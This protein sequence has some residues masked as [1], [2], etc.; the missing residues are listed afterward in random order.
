MIQ[1]VIALII[2]FSVLSFVLVSFCRSLKPLKSGKSGKCNGCSGCDMLNSLKK[3]DKGKLV[4]EK[5]KAR[6]IC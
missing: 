2:V 4:F 1:N 6:M 5:A 3:N